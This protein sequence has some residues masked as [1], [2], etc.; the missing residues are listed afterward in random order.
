MMYPQTTTTITTE[1]RKI[2]N[3]K[4]KTIQLVQKER[5]MIP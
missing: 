2:E 5:T 3:R 1:V 4:I